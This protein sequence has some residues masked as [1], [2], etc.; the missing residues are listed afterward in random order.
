MQASCTRL[1]ALKASK[2]LV[3]ELTGVDTGRLKWPPSSSAA[4]RR[5]TD[6]DLDVLLSSNKTPYAF[7]SLVQPTEVAT[8]HH[9]FEQ[10]QDAVDRP[11]A[12][13]VKSIEVL[14]ASCKVAQDITQEI[15]SF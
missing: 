4:S 9:A 1:L 5:R 11:R 14:L 6:H 13:D 12:R 10:D 2:E 7:P 15:D 3:T 8:P